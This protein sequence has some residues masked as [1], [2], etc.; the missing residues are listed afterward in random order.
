MHNCSIQQN[1]GTLPLSRSP[2]R[3]IWRFGHRIIGHS[4]FARDS[5]GAEGGGSWQAAR[6]VTAARRL[7]LDGSAQYFPSALTALHHKPRRDWPCFETRDNAYR[8]GLG[9][10]CCGGSQFVHLFPQCYLSDCEF[11]AILDEINK[12]SL[13]LSSHNKKRRAKASC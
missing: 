11:I 3:G 6:H 7:H 4:G 2:C 8:P 1:A 9:H 13:K 12:D 5:N 10:V